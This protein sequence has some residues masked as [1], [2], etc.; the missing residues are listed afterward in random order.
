MREDVTL[1]M[2][3][4]IP[5]RREWDK[6]RRPCALDVPIVEKTTGL[7]VC[8]VAHR[9]SQPYTLARARAIVRANNDA[10]NAFR[11]GKSEKTTS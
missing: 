7:L 11:K 5:L 8:L 4:H 3:W 2:H 6:H 10:V 9:R 1:R